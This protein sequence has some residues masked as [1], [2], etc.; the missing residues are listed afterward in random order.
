M[1]WPMAIYELR[2]PIIRFISHFCLFGNVLIWLGFGPSER[3]LDKRDWLTAD[4][5]SGK[6]YCF[7]CLLFAPPGKP[8]AWSAVNQG[9]EN[10]HRLANCLNK[11]EGKITGKGKE[12]VQNSH[13]KAEVDWRRF[14]A[15]TDH[16]T[17]GTMPN[18]SCRQVIQ[19][20]INVN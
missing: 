15:Q 5:Q 17:P 13:K 3:L 20:I 8:T 18:M 14:L 6:L 4:E 2:V 10:L 7:A 1:S 12:A 11:H 16:Q 19:V 9:F